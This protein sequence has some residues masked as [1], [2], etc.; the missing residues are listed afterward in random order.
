MQ[1]S[2]AVIST[3]LHAGRTIVRAF[4]PERPATGFEPVRAGLEDVYFAA[5]GGRLAPAREGVAA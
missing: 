5:V 3:R 4:A 2:L 1:Q